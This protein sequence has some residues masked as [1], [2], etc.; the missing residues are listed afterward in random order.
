MKT[1]I[2]TLLVTTAFGAVAI[3][4]ASAMPFNKAPPSESLVLDVRMVCDQYGRCYNT[5]RANRAVRYHNRPAYYG[6]GPRYGYAS[7]GYDGHYARPG[8]GVGIGPLGVR[9]Y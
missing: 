2:A 5:R 6:G 8:V 4:G 1:L 7:R 9:I 3:G